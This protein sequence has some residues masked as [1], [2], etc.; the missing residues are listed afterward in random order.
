MPLQ[1]YGTESEL[2]AAAVRRYIQRSTN[3]VLAVV[4]FATAL[5]CA[6]TGAKL[7]SPRLRRALLALGVVV[8][9][10]TAAWLATFPVT[11]SV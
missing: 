10:G 3:Y 9:V 8:F 1:R 2:S 5:F 6:G 7:P 4:L 11:V